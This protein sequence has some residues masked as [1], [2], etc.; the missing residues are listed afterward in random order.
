MNRISGNRTKR[1]QRFANVVDGL[2]PHD[3][4]EVLL[5]REFL[6]DKASGMT[7]EELYAKYGEDYLGRSDLA[8]AIPRTLVDNEDNAGRIPGDAGYMGPGR[9]PFER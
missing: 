7:W 6:K 2:T 1:R 5:F 8:V 3:R 4:G 9:G